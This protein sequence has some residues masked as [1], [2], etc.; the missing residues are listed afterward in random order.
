M[1]C[2]TN[3]SH[4]ASNDMNVCFSCFFQVGFSDSTA[5][6]AVLLDKKHL[7]LGCCK[8]VSSFILFKSLF[9][10]VVIAQENGQ[11]LM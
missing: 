5:V 10:A 2:E 3:S 6:N 4:C 11:Q 9:L 8:I 1:G 7:N